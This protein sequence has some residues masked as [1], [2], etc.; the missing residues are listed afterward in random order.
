MVEK[1]ASSFLTP[2][3]DCEGCSTESISLKICSWTEPEF[4]TAYQGTLSCL[5]SFPCLNSPLPQVPPEITPQIKCLYLYH[6]LGS[7]FGEI[8]TGQ[9][10][11]SMIS[12]IFK[13]V[14]ILSSHWRASWVGIEFLIHQRTWFSDFLILLQKRSLWNTGFFVFC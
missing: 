2:G 11:N 13:D 9:L 7:A 14:F 3:S 1:S 5:S 4:P 10:T 6:V 8:Q 12:H